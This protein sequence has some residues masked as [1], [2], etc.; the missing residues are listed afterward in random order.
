[1]L[2]VDLIGYGATLLTTVSL[3]PEVYRVW[4]RRK[5]R[6]LSF[7]WLGFLGTGQALWLVYGAYIGSTPL[8]MS[9]SASLIICAILTVLAVKFDGIKIRK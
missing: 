7:Y 1:M 3:V 6:D 5:A 9:S 8:V 4:V 2:G